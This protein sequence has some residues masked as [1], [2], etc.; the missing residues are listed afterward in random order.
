[1]ARSAP[2]LLTTMPM[3]STSAGASRKLRTCSESAICGTAAEET[4]ETASMCRKPA[5]MSARRY[6]ALTST[7]ISFGN[8]CQASRGHSMSLTGAVISESSLLDVGAGHQEDE[9][10]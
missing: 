10:D 2:F 3:I 7:G 9:E 5:A 4:K 6:S 1:M 8:P